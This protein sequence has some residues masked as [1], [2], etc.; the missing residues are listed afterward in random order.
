MTTN[1]RIVLISLFALSIFPAIALPNTLPAVTAYVTAAG[2]YNSGSI[3]VFFDRQISS[4]S[5][6]NRLDISANHPALKNI[7]SIA[8]AAYMS[9]SA[10]RIHPGSC[11]GTAP[12]FGAEGDS[13]FYLTKDVPT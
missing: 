10:V 8:M 6:S 2:T 5:S 9:G 3:Y 11:A 4:C 1:K 12:Y 13:H 7:L